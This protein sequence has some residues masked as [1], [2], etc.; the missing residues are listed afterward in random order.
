MTIDLVLSG[1]V[2]GAK[3]T[4]VPSGWATHASPT[5]SPTEGRP[6]VRKPAPG[7]RKRF[8]EPSRSS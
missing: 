6:G 7:R 1:S 3:A 5:Y 4:I 2:M 8:D